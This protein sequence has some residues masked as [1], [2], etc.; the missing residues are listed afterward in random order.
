MKKSLKNMKKAWP[1][2]KNKGR[3]E[4]GERKKSS[5]EGVKK[6]DYTQKTAEK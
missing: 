1:E 2:V 4:R 3:K 6:S 5:S